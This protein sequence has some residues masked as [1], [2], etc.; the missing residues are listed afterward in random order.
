MAGFSNPIT[1]GQ[2]ALDIPAIKSPN[3]VPG[4]SGWSINRSGSAEFNNLS[5]RGTFRGTNFIIDATGLYFYIGVPA[6]GNPPV[7][8]VTSA[9]VDPFGN[10][11]SGTVGVNGGTGLLQFLTPGVPG[12]S[13]TIADG[14]LQRIIANVLATEIRLDQNNLPVVNQI[15]MT[16]K[17]NFALLDAI[18]KLTAQF[19]STIPPQLTLAQAGMFM[20]A[21]NNLPVANSA[22]ETWH[23]LRPLVNSFVGTNA[24]EWPPQFRVS[25][26]GDL[27]LFG[28]VQLPAAGGY[29]GI[30]WQTLPVGYRV[31]RFSSIPV[32]QLGG[33]MSTNNTGGSPRLFTDSTGVLQFGGISPAINSTIIRF[34]GRIPLLNAPISL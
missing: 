4:V 30:T 16:A 23:D 18:L 29:N 9:V 17:S 12:D 7:F 26:D 19:D 14:I 3:Y 11:V 20:N 34:S 6:N 13:M 25:S 22:P 8:F 1:G 15:S 2:G 31:T 5:I 27:E 33:A 21:A 24:N 28:A 10:T 32:V